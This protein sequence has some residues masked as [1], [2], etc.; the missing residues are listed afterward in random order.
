MPPAGPVKIRSMS[1]D[2]DDIVRVAD[3]PVKNIIESE[4]KG[5][6]RA[7]ISDVSIEPDMKMITPSAFTPKHGKS[8]SIIKKA[9]QKHFLFQTLSEN[10]L[11]DIIGVM[12]FVSHEPPQDVIEQGD[13]GNKFYILESGT[14]DILVNGLKVGSYSS[15]DAFGEL[16]LMYNCPRA[17]TIRATSTCA[18]W[19]VDRTSF[20][21]ILATTASSSQVARVEF[22]NNV[23][24]LEPLSHNQLQTVA[25]AMN[26]EDFKDGEYIIHQGDEGETFY[27]IVEGEVI[28]TSSEAG[29]K[30][31]K[32]LMTLGVGDYFG[33]MALM[34]NQ[35]RQAN[36]IAHGPIQCLTLDRTNFTQ[37]LGPLR[38]LID[39]QMRIRVLKSVPLLKSLSDDELDLLAHALNVVVFENGKKIIT[40]GEEGSTFY[41]VSEGKVNVFKSGVQVMT[42]GSGEFF[43]ERAL[44]KKEP[45]AADCIALGR[46]ECLVLDREAFEKQLGKLEH[47][48]ERE[49]KRQE[50]L[51]DIVFNEKGSPTRPPRKKSQS[52]FKLTDFE[53]VRTIGT[54]TFGRVTL[55]YHKTTKQAMALKCMQKATVVTAHQQRNVIHEKSII[56][57]C[58]HPLILKLY[59]TFADAD[60]L[61][62][63]L[64]LV[65]GGE[66]WSLL[67]EKSHLLAPGPYG[68]FD[69][70]TSRF[71][72]ANVTSI[73]HYLSKSGVAY[74]DLKPENLLIDHEGYLKMVDF[75]F[76]KHIPF[77]KGK[78][79]CT[80]SF[81]LCGTP[82][83]LAPELVLSKGHTSSVDYWALG[84]LIYELLVGNTP[85]QDDEQQ[86]IF[87][88]IIHVQKSLT[89]PVGFDPKAQDLIEKLLNPNPALR[90][91]AL[92]GGVSDIMNHEWFTIV[93]FNWDALVNKSI[94][95]PYTPPIK[96][97]HDASNFDLYPEDEF[98][99]QYKGP[100]YFEG[101]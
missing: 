31:E 94:R 26:K 4:K 100:D 32:E 88:K 97:S 91:G 36:C 75:G 52:E 93:N 47:I 35:P 30:I 33:E 90:L 89:F 66:L 84:C 34:L 18:L 82:E 45:R 68:S 44:L 23:P 56:A 42:L 57:E 39:R 11:L 14:C 2:D 95:A 79:L 49:M 70:A 76:A 78:S 50:R 92:V 25:A 20:R 61:Y 6:R 64:E 101:F 55:V 17:A 51:Q 98:V 9:L 59:G 12:A 83:Y 38:Q 85:F 10:E 7:P 3:I 48:M 69:M 29:T 13:T 19:S 99:T 67:Y 1:V 81:T 65:Q 21:R 5:V 74:R 15:G 54:G 80:K 43:G 28:C 53:K 41:I 71:Y 60:Q 27:L 62:M 77:Y 22:L 63:L 87:E 8:S 24:L 16:A 58:D 96:D 46:V 73:F 86:R 40:C 72:A 37:L